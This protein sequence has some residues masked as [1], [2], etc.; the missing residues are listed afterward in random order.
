MDL[1]AYVK[2]FGSLKNIP[3]G[4]HAVIPSTPIV[5]PGVIFVLKNVNNEVNI[6]KLN[7]L[8][9]YYLVYMDEQGEVRMN[10]LDSKR[11]LDIM[12]MTCRNQKEPLTALCEQVIQDTSN[13]HNMEQFSDL[14]QRSIGS[15]LDKEEES[16]VQSLFSA[17]GTLGIH[18]MFKGIEDFKLIAFLMVK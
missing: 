18:E 5:P 11:I 9:P 3:V 15:I 17:G 10:H 6:N 2:E 16:G 8:H 14:L 7:R 12:R 4:L 13:Y 1:L